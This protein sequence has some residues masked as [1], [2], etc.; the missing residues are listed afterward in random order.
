MSSGFRGWQKIAIPSRS[1]ELTECDDNPTESGQWADD[2]CSCCRYR[3]HQSVPFTS[4]APYVCLTIPLLSPPSVQQHWLSTRYR[5]ISPKIPSDWLITHTHR[6]DVSCYC[7][8]SPNN[9]RHQI[10]RDFPSYQNLV[11]G[12]I[13]WQQGL[14]VGHAV[15]HKR[16][17][18]QGALWRMM[19]TGC[20]QS[21]ITILPSKMIT[22]VR[23]GL[24][25]N[26]P[27]DFYTGDAAFQRLG[28]GRD[29]EGG[30]VGG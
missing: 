11:M 19:R 28:R 4:G 23:V 27:V 14:S 22:D 15:R 18:Y 3:P 24:S 20:C 1:L 8:F 29:A 25:A 2:S 17:Q 7:A 21:I 16:Y 26:R 6:E 30:G 13:G 10:S 9:K 5:R 12:G